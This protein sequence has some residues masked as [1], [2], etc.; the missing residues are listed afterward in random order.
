MDNLNCNS[1]DDNLHEPERTY[2][3]ASHQAEIMNEVLLN[4][5]DLQ[6]L[7]WPHEMNANYRETD[8]EFFQQQEEIFA[9]DE[10]LPHPLITSRSEDLQLIRNILTFSSRCSNVSSVE[11]DKHPYSFD[12]QRTDSN[13]KPV[14]RRCE[15][16]SNPLKSKKAKLDCPKLE[17]ID[18]QREGREEID[19]E[20]IAQVKEMIYRAAALR[21][22]SLGVEEMVEKPRR[23][24]LKISSDPQTTAARH[25]RERISERL[26]VLQRLVPG[27]RKMDTASM[28]DEAASYLKFLK[29]QV[30]ALEKNSHGSSL[31]DMKIV[32]LNCC[33]G[34]LPFPVTL[35]HYSSPKQTCIFPLPRH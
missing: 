7:I 24:N 3:E 27:G 34:M 35:S 28:L 4:S 18:F 20:A 10:L 12:D 16:S 31:G 6:E 11:S 1:F 32:G 15:D 23:K 25:R 29:A 9:S 22:V 17:S 2:R 8:Q 5:L 33:S 26:R 19:G 13:I 14:T 30:T 21:P